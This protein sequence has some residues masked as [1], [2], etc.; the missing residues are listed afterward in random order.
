MLCALLW[1]AGGSNPRK[2]DAIVIA[3]ATLYAVSNVSEVSSC[4]HFYRL[5]TFWGGFFGG[6][7]GGEEEWTTYCFVM[8]MMV[9]HIIVSIVLI[10]YGKF[11]ENDHCWNL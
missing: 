4:K 5:Q 6:G 3:G 11:M 8:Y 9:Q 10:Y 1:V 7:G 2:G